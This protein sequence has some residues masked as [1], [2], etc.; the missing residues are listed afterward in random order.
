MD[1]LIG[2]QS[3]FT[4]RRKFWQFLGATVFVEQPDGSPIMQA[5]LKAFRLKEDVRFY[6][7]ENRT[8]ELLRISA[9]Q[10][11][12]FGATYDVFDSVNNQKLGAIRRKGFKSMLRDEWHILNL[13]D[14]TVAV[15]QEDSVS[16]ALL[17][18]FITNLIPQKFSLTSSDGQAELAFAQQNFNPF[19]VVLR[20]E[21]KPELKQIIDPRLALTVFTLLAAVEGR[22]S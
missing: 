9:R 20:I 14:Q 13:E 8:V 12:D 7:D 21:T 11:I 3:N 2:N 22:Q 19:T 15:L 5:K 4:V 6:Q 10:M 17:R 18:R 16:L 1:E